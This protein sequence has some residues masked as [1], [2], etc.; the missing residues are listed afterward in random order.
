MINTGKAKALLFSFV[1]WTDERAAIRKR[2]IFQ[3]IL[4][5]ASIR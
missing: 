5:L 1:H 4:S 3:L 2:Q